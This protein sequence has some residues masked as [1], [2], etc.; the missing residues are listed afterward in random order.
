M[1]KALLEDEAGRCSVNDIEMPLMLSP[2][3]KNRSYLAKKS[4]PEPRDI[5][6]SCFLTISCSKKLLFLKSW[7]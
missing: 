5:F 4:T 7:V 3:N 1:K 2:S 6:F